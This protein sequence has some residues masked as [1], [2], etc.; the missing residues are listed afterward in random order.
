MKDIKDLHKR[1]HVQISLTANVL[2]D[3]F[4]PDW[5]AP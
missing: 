2:I 4:K 1:R 3:I 5:F